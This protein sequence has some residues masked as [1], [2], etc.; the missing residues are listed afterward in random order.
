MEVHNRAK[1]KNAH[2]SNEK[3]SSDQFTIGDRRPP[4]CSNILSPSSLDTVRRQRSNSL[5]ANPNSADIEIDNPLSHTQSVVVSS[6]SEQ[7]NN[8]HNSLL[9]Q[10]HQPQ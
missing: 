8:V 7:T 5:I 1:E 6:M 4:E 2:L 10:I 9:E 3:G